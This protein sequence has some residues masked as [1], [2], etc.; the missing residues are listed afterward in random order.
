MEDRGS[1]YKP[2]LQLIGII[3]LCTH[4]FNASFHFSECVLT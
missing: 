4:V 3:H 2:S 1:H